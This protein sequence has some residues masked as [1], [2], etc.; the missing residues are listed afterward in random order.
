MNIANINNMISMSASSNKLNLAFNYAKTYTEIVVLSYYVH[1]CSYL[2]V[3]LSCTYNSIII[4]CTIIALQYSSS[5]I[6]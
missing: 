5:D 2:I 1:S 3:I 6:Q 4:L